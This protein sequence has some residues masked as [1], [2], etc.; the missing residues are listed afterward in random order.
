MAEGRQRVDPPSWGPRQGRPR[1]LVEARDDRWRAGTVGALEAGGYEVIGCEGPKPELEEP[2]PAVDG[3]RCPGAA[4]ADVVVC[5]F[6]PTDAH[7]RSLPG[8]VAHELREG[9]SVLVLASPEDA[10]RHREALEGCRLLHHPVDQDDLLAEVAIAVDELVH[11][12][13]PQTGRT[14]PPWARPPRS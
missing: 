10:A 12:P 7:S 2:C 11:T 5:D 4:H 13:A 3:A 6:D 8:A 1:V 9:A 14:R